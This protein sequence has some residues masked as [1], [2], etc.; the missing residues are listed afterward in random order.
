MPVCMKCGA[1]KD[2]AEFHVRKGNKSSRTCKLCFKADNNARSK[3]HNDLKSLQKQER[4]C[5]SCRKYLP[6]AAF[7]TKD[8]ISLACKS[9][10]CCACLVKQSELEQRKVLLMRSRRLR[11]RDPVRAN[12]YKIG[13]TL[14]GD[15]LSI[16]VSLDE[17][18]ALLDGAT[19]CE[20]CGTT[21]E[22]CGASG[23]RIPLSRTKMVDHNHATGK[24]RG[25]LCMHCNSALGHLR[26][27]RANIRSL[28][29]YLDKY[30]PELKAEAR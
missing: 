30:E 25:V 9:Y 21:L 1:E 14:R 19:S 24:V 3:V 12:W 7:P 28:L 15:G 5:V 29:A 13:S 27:S 16:S 4:W 11:T 8:T 17:Y 23:P 10:R 18:R 26:E 22:S 6:V 2:V 20:I